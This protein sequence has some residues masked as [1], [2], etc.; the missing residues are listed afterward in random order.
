M[1]FRT[2]LINSVL[3]MPLVTAR[4]NAVTAAWTN[5]CCS[6]VMGAVLGA[7]ERLEPVPHSSPNLCALQ[8]RELVSSQFHE[9]SCPIPPVSSLDREQ[10]DLGWTVLDRRISS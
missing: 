6:R 3:L 9:I 4:L 5:S 7:R 2:K 1:G 8:V 10:L